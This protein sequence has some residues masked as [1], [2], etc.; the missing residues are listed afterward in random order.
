MSV[1]D[2]A[3][4]LLRGLDWKMKAEYSGSG[5]ITPGMLLI[6]DAAAGTVAAHSSTGGISQKMFARRAL[7]TTGVGAGIDTNYAD[8]DITRVG[9]ARSGDRVNAIVNAG[10]SVTVNDWLVSDGAGGVQPRAAETFDL[11]VGKAVETVADPVS[12]YARVEIEVL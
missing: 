12:G 6:Y 11:V 8:G 3:T 2:P 5:V 4:I 10:T 1:K 9:Y 7:A